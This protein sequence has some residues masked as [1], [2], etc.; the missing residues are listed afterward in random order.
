MRSL[1]HLPPAVPVLDVRRQ[2]QHGEDQAK[3]V[4]EDMPLPSH[5]LLSGVIAA[6]T[7]HLRSLCRLA[8]NDPSRRLVRMPLPLPNLTTESIIDPLPRPVPLPPAK[9]TVDQ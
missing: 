5:N 3:H 2:H 1:Q 8:V 6:R 9:V 7:A 4:D